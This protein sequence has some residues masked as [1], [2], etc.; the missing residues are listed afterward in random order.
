MALTGIDKV[1]L[2]KYLKEHAN[3]DIYYLDMCDYLGKRGKIKDHEF[4]DHFT[5]C[6]IAEFSKEGKISLKH[7]AKMIS[8]V[9]SFAEWMHE[10]KSEIKEE[11]TEIIKKIQ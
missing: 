4:L 3:G 2:N 5:D 10:E 8:I 9:G 6:V 11:I 7:A 1:K